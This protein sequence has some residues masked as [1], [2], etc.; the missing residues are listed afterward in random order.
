ML[1]FPGGSVVKNPLANTGD[2]GLIFGLERSPGVGND[3][4]LV[5][6]PGQF[7][8]QRSLEGFSIQSHKESDKISH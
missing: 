5:F 1:G 6:L 7:H 8:G 3:N 2:A 4:P